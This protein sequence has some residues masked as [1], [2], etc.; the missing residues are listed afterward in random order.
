MRPH[1]LLLAIASLALPLALTGCINTDAAVFVEPTIESPTATVAGGALGVTISGEFKLNL[2][3]GP[4]ASGPSEVSLGGFA[5]LDAD[6]KAEITSVQLGAS[7]IQF[8]VTVEPDVD[9]L[10][11]FP[12]DLG[13]KTLPAT[14]KDQA[15]GSLCDPRGVILRGTIQD[16]LLGGSTPFFSEIIHPAGC[17]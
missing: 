12:F 3:L 7:A 5:L 4:R 11:T 6:Q 10:A 13:S 8:P 15:A 2:H 16:S 17:L 14:A 1:L 9:A